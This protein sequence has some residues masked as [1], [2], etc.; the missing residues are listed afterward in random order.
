MLEDLILNDADR[1]KLDGIVSEM[2]SNGESDEYI[3][4]VV[5][6]FK[7]KYSKK[8]RFYG[9]RLCFGRHT[10]SLGFVV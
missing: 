3:Q 6:D 8:K 10:Y 5:D 9:I 1:N 4:G 7:S 2:I